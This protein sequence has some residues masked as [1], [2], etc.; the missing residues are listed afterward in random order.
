MVATSG[1]GT[2]NVFRGCPSVL[3]VSSVMSTW[4]HR[5]FHSVD[6]HWAP[7]VTSLVLGLGLGLRWTGEHRSQG[8]P[9]PA[10]L[11]YCGVQGRDCCNPAR[12]GIIRDCTR[13]R[14]LAAISPARAWPTSLSLSLSCP[15]PCAQ[16]HAAQAPGPSSWLHPLQGQD[17]RT[18]LPHT[19]SQQQQDTDGPCPWHAWS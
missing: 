9:S 7:P 3:A 5:L 18:G 16:P 13:E 11:G 4:G 6:I 10:W 12:G 17:P 15:E 2:S 1:N 14:P 19:L 8:S